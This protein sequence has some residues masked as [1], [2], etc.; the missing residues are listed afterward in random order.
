MKIKW[1]EVGHWGY[2]LTECR[3]PPL[4][5]A[6][7]YNALRGFSSAMPSCLGSQLSTAWNFYKPGQKR[8]LLLLVVGVVGYCVPAIRK[9]L[10]QLL[11]GAAV[12]FSRGGELWV[13][14]NFK[15]GEIWGMHLSK[16]FI[17]L[18]VVFDTRSRYVVQASLLTRDGSLASASQGQEL[19][20]CTT[21][22]R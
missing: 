21:R 22:R 2:G 16:T 8:P 6:S 7:L 11:G 5:S 10:G 13:E 17:L 1:V 19:Q 3:P 20:A 15:E 4:N 14:I 18:F 9:Q 12:C